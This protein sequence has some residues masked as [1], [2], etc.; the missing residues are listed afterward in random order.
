MWSNAGYSTRRFGPRHVD[1][2]V[3]RGESELLAIRERTRR[4]EHQ[5]VVEL[6]AVHAREQLGEL[7]AQQ[8][9]RKELRRTF[10][11]QAA[12]HMTWRALLTDAT[13]TDRWDFGGVGAGHYL[14]ASFFFKPFLSS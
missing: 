4:R 8:I 13:H 7:L 11:S 10:L 9:E 6:L 2:R 5:I 14:P 12:N 1:S 3:G